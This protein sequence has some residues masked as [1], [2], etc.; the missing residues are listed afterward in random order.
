[1]YESYY[2]HYNFMWEM[3]RSH[4]YSRASYFPVFWLLVP[5]LTHFGMCFYAS[6]HFGLLCRRNEFDEVGTFDYQDHHLWNEEIGIF[7]LNALETHTGSY[8]SYFHQMLNT[9]KVKQFY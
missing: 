9:P 4:F 7:L 2:G 3:I 6:Y 1:M 8:F 5:I